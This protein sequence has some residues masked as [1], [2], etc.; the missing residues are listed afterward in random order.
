MRCRSLQLS[1]CKVRRTVAYCVIQ[2]Y[3]AS[4]GGVACFK[5]ACGPRVA[6][7]EG[8]PTCSPP[9]TRICARRRWQCLTL[10][11]NGLE[12]VIGRPE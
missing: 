7:T 6:P 8:I 5:L 10:A 4:Q 1:A 2:L 3:S 9:M 12:V 11:A